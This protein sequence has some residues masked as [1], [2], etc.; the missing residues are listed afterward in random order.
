ME[1]NSPNTPLSGLSVSAD[2]E[3]VVQMHP[4]L[5]QLII[6]TAAYWRAGLI[7]DVLM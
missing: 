2:G 4:S 3:G 1:M 5:N 7:S 6:L